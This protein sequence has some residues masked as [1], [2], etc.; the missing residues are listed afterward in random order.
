MGRRSRCTPSRET[1]G[2]TVPRSPA[3]LSISSMKI[4]PWFS[5]RS[6]AS[7][8]TSSMSTS[9]FS[10]SSI[11]MRRASWRCTVRRFLRLG[12]I[13]CSHS[14]KLK[15]GPS[16]PGGGCI[17][18]SI[19]KLCCWT[20][21]STSRSSSLPSR[22][23]WRSF[24]R[25]RR[26]RSC[27]S[28]SVSSAFCVTSPL[29]DTTNRGVFSPRASPRSPAAAGDG[30]RVHVVF[31][32]RAH[33]VDGHV[34]QLAHHG[35]HVAAHVADLGELRRLDL[36]ERRAREPGQPPGDLGFPHARGPDED[37]VVRQDLVADLV[38]GLGAAPAIAD[39]DGDGAFRDLLP[40]HVAV[41]LGHDLARRQLLEPGKRLFFLLLGLGRRRLVG[42]ARGF[43]HHNSRM[44]ICALVYTQMSAAISSDRCTISFADSDE[45]PSRARAAARA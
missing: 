19:G 5:T 9:F 26:R 10:S 41:E 2:P 28:V 21:T 20:S 22:S 3:I 17:I 37:D 4:T 43:G 34:H 33:H 39:G 13:S 27:A 42:G 23:C 18:S 30:F 24:S 44:V 25:V 36:E 32:L 15:S 7:F 12:S 1:S 40:D 45:A 6:S 31:A 38:G 35:L 14:M 8:T 11:R 16:M 29:D